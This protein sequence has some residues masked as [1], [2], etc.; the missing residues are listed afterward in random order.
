MLTTDREQIRRYYCDIYQRHLAGQ[1]LDAMATLVLDVILLH[2]EYH[3]LLAQ[4]EQAI[5]LDASPERGTSNPFLHM[6]MH[7]AIRE[8]VTTNRPAG[9]A[10]IYQRLVK[11]HGQ[12]EAEH[13]MME[14]LASA[15][16]QSQQ[17]NKPPNEQSYL[18]CLQRV[19]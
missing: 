10:A 15:L 9:I 17:D 1:P 3:S 18:D 12:S 14:C 13:R 7:L 2:P 6:G 16:W 19:G 8:Q 11:H 5:H 4:P